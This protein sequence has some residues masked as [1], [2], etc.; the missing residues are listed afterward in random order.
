[1]KRESG[2][3]F[4][5][6]VA[7][8]NH[9]S[10][11]C[12][13]PTLQVS[14]H[15]LFCSV[16]YLCLNSYNLSIVTLLHLRIA[17]TFTCSWIYVRLLYGVTINITHKELIYTLLRI[18][19]ILSHLLTRRDYSLDNKR[20]AMAFT[21]IQRSMIFTTDCFCSLLFSFI[22]FMRCGASKI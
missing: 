14:V 11:T 12:T 8:Y 4:Y 16:I 15:N 10:A 5:S 9:L 21:H 3:Y 7:T 1:M 18:L 6:L 13:R 2:S 17:I 19:Y 22:S 20:I